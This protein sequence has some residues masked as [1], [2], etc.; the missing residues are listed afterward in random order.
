M[1]V[2]DLMDVVLE[3]LQ[4][5]EQPAPA[6]EGAFLCGA[7]GCC[8]ATAFGS[9]GSAGGFCAATAFGSIGSAGGGN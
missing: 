9:I 8:A 2:D 5:V 3:G 1:S 7:G 6:D 4:E